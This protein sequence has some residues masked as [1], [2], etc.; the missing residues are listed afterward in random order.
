MELSR[1]RMSNMDVLE[2]REREVEYS[3][4]RK[5]E[6]RRNPGDVPMELMEAVGGVRP[7]G[8]SESWIRDH[9]VVVFVVFQKW[10]CRRGL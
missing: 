3:K 1:R 10:H 9:P 2:K 6:V 7:T 4:G 5:G 8:G